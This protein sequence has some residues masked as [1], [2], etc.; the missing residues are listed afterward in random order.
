MSAI[1]AASGWTRSSRLLRRVTASP[2]LLGS[3]LAP[4][5]DEGEVESPAVGILELALGL[6]AKPLQLVRVD[7]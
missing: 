3:P 5:L 1:D 2:R 7:Q 6:R 4:A